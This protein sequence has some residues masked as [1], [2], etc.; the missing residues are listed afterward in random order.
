MKDRDGD[1]LRE[2]AEALRRRPEDARP[3]ETAQNV[4]RLSRS[5]GET[6]EGAEQRTPTTRREPG[7]DMTSPA[8]FADLATSRID[9]ET[10]QKD[11]PEHLRGA[12]K[13]ARAAHQD[14]LAYARYLGGSNVR[15]DIQDALEKSCELM[16]QV[17]DGLDSATEAA[18]EWANEISLPSFREAA[19]PETP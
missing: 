5:G 10:W 18:Q 13:I 4:F 8:S 17:A 2:L 12:A 11:L 16:D 19:R 14:L 15:E 7:E 6:D 1:L 3:V 9:Q